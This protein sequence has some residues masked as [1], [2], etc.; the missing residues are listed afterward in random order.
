M[1]HV[2]RRKL[3]FNLIYKCHLLFN[4]SH[5]ISVMSR[6]LEVTLWM[7][8]LYLPVYIMQ[9]L[10]EICSLL[11]PNASAWGKC[12]VINHLHWSNQQKRWIH[13]I[14]TLLGCH[15]SKRSINVYSY[16][17]LENVIL[18]I[19]QSGHSSLEKWAW[20]KGDGNGPASKMNVLRASH[21]SAEEVCISNRHSWQIGVIQPT[22]N[23]HL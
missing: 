20:M 6:S 9:Y 23:R 3:N 2:C 5:N 17:L 19:L 12:W 21:L 11:I 16:F 1:I 10:M 22:G 15:S 8:F 18:E 13:C 4:D 7:T 14:L